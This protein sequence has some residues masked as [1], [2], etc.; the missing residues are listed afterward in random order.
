MT[1]PG[2][3]VAFQKQIGIQFFV[4]LCQ[5]GIRLLNKFESLILNKKDGVEI[6]VNY[7]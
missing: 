1:F 7:K 2:N 4:A 5:K 3:N 6:V